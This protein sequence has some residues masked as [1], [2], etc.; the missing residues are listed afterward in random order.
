MKQFENKETTI[1]V[2][3]EDELITAKYSD[4]IKM[5]LKMPT[6]EGLS[7]DDIEHRVRI[8]SALNTNPISLEDAD[9]KYLVNLIKRTRW[10]FFHED[11]LK[12]RDDLCQ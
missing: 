2:Q 7:F 4:L 9:F 6:Q 12:F 8:S 1:K 5:A 10:N 3:T 11:L